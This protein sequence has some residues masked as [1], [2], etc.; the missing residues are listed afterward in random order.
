M[1]NIAFA[2]NNIA[3]WPLSVSSAEAGTFDS[4][5]V[6]YSFKL[7]RFQTINSPM[8][9][10]VPGDTSWVHFRTHF[11]NVAFLDGTTLINAY[12]ANAN[13]LFSA[14][15]PESFDDPVFTLQLHHEAGTISVVS[16]V[17]VNEGLVN[18]IDFKYTAAVGSLTVEAYV[19]GALGASATIANNTGGYGSV[20]SLTI[21]A[22]WTG[23]NPTDYQNFSE[24]LVTD[25]DSRN[26]RINLLRATA[27]GG[28]TDWIGDATHL[29]DDDPTSGMTTTTVEQRQTVDLSAY[30][31]AQNISNVIVASQSYAGANGPQNIRHT[32]RMSTVNYDSLADIPIADVLQYELTNFQINPATSLPWVGTDLATMEIGFISKT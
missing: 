23:A 3:H 7:I 28:E 5:R 32:V 12:D 11:T 6:P 8:F 2:S 29:G 20:A 31:G 16:T 30:V 25:V 13:L 27:S 18:Q 14:V 24:F 17:P 22:I 19:N 26:A 4:T 10:P 9:T 1:A 21:G 15:K